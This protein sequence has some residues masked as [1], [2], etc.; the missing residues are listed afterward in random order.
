MHL[1]GGFPVVGLVAVPLL[2]AAVRARSP[3]HEETLMAHRLPASKSENTPIERRTA[4]LPFLSGRC[5]DP[6]TT[7][8]ALKSHP[9]SGPG[10]LQSMYCITGVR[11]MT[12][13]A[14]TRSTLD[15]ERWLSLERPGASPADLLGGQNP[16]PCDHPLA[17][18]RHGPRGWAYGAGSEPSTNVGR[19]KYTRASPRL[20][21]IRGGHCQS[22]LTI[23]V[24][25]EKR[26]VGVASSAGFM[27]SYGSRTQTNV[28][29]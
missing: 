5:T 3:E 12:F 8:S 21:P 17:V 19:L 22:C 28:G 14:K 26:L 27:H 13:C 15:A 11:E 6:S 10:F 25:P 9:I 20:R 2:F 18:L 23:T 1:S 24:G 4:G 29:R 7:S 16:S